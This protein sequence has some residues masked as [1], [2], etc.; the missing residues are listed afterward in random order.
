MGRKPTK[1]QAQEFTFAGYDQKQYKR[2]DQYAAAID[3]L[4]NAAVADFAKLANQ[5]N[6]DP[7]QCFSFSDMPTL[8]K[9]AQEIV[10]ALASKM[11]AVI[12]H[13]SRESWLY[14]CQKND[15]FLNHIMNTAKIGKRQLKRMQD[16]N[17]T[18]LDAFQT[19][20]TNGMDL[21]QRVWKY[22][23]ETKDLIELGIDIAVGDG[24]PATR[25]AK[26]L[27]GYLQEPNKLFRRV[28]DKH[29]NLVLSKRAAA[30]HPGQGVYRSSYQNA[31][32]LARTEVNMAYRDSD[33][34][35]WNQLDFV[36]GYEVHLSNSHTCKG[37]KKGVKYKDVCDELAGK[38]PKEFVFKGWHPNCRCFMTP[39]L[40]DPKEFK[41][42]QENALRD[43]FWGDDD[44]FDGE[45]N[46]RKYCDSS[47][48][49]IVD[50]P[51]GFK[52]WAKANVERAKGWSTMPYFIKDNFTG[53]TLE[54]DLKLVKPSIPAPVKAEETITEDQ[55]QI[56]AQQ[57]VIADL[58]TKANEWGFTTA[59]LNQAI[60]AGKYADVMMEI[61]N[62]KGRIDD[63]EK[64]LADYLAEA[65][66]AMA[67]AT[68]R[69][70]DHSVVRSD[71]N[72]A[73]KDKK[74]FL[75]DK[76]AYKKHVEDLKAKFNDDVKAVTTADMKFTPDNSK[77]APADRLKAIRDGI[78]LLNG[79]DNL[80]PIDK[81]YIE[82]ADDALASGSDRQIKWK[83]DALK[84][85]RQ[86]LNGEDKP[87]LLSA[88]H[89]TELKAI[90]P[91]DIRPE[92]RKAYN[93][94]VAAI[95]AHDFDAKG[96]TPAIFQKIEAAYNIYKLGTMK[97]VAK[98]GIDKVSRNTPYNLFT[99][100]MKKIPNFT[101]ADIPSKEFFDA[102]DD[103][104]PLH[105]LSTGGHYDPRRHYVNI[106][107]GKDNKERMGDSV[108]YRK[109]LFHHEFGHAFD[110][111]KGL[112][113]DPEIKQIFDKA[114]ADF[115]KIDAQLEKQIKDMLSAEE[116]QYD[117]IIN[118]LGA[119]WIAT[120]AGTP[121]RTK[122]LADYDA[123][124]ALK[125]Q[126][127]MDFE[128]RLG[129][130]SDTFQALRAGHKI[131]PPRGHSSSYFASEEKQMAEFLAHASENV[132]SGND[133]FEKIA[134]DL[135]KE[136]RRV[137]GA[138]MKKH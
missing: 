25:M 60:K 28:R 131:V 115:A 8:Q 86:R 34:Y 87:L 133:L 2:S 91:A 35:R 40:K 9:K 117:D 92:W 73:K 23:G 90:K 114:K 22:A 69:K 6:V 130:F 112:K 37:L 24:T 64:E 80:D 10:N 89:A 88:N 118:D 134:P 19:R 44:D 49:Q 126:K 14:A 29:G 36:V 94:A 81:Y 43:A 135:Y 110:H 7:D 11:T 101:T 27:K 136:M 111:Q 116:K 67:E 77:M 38:Y 17:L 39:I 127:M 76:V 79:K 97:E 33:R 48:N 1:P 18:A 128:E 129:A 98:F 93:D 106:S 65:D 105:A 5:A 107:F 51:S 4:Y 46:Y 121:E 132:W 84:T 103:F 95:N 78:E 104:I 124:V 42:D 74:G 56:Q 138:K 123:A 20:K 41:T 52:S 59:K 99:E 113:N 85:I 125:R 119:K 15:A 66:N 3:Q 109:G 82:M 62:L 57:G 12:Q 61:G 45:G 102:F 16:R 75:L 100:Y 83:L 53:G 68:K 32:R 50:V 47:V 58:M 55:K 13:G 96:I 71:Y 122:A 30:Y 72:D 120:K 137:F 63:A 70:I 31:L 21:S 108:W 26:E 54:G